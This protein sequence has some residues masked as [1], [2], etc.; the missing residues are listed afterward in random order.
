MTLYIYVFSYRNTNYMRRKPFR[1]G[2]HGSSFAKTLL[3]IFAV[4]KSCVLSRKTRQL[5]I[6]HPLT[7]IYLILKKS[8]LLTLSCILLSIWMM[9]HDMSVKT[10]HDLNSNGKLKS[11]QRFNCPDL[12]LSYN[13]DSHMPHELCL[14]S[15]NNEL[16]C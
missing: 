3:H 6:L 15:K 13:I 16:K 1:S 14:F 11:I 7:S 10:F 4:Q 9:Y 12:C 5:Y 8:N 2:P